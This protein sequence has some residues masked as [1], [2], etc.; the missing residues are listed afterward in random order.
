VK[1]LKKFYS[2]L[3]VVFVACCLNATPSF[4]I[5]SAL[6]LKSIFSESVDLRLEVPVE[7]Q[8]LYSELLVGELHRFGLK[9]LAPQYVLLVDRSPKVQAIFLLWIQDTDHVQFIGA[10]PVST[11][12]KGGFKYFETPLGI[13]SHTIENS[14]FRAEGTENEQGILGYGHKGM[15]VYDFGW[16]SARKT[17]QE[18]NGIMRLQVHSTDPRHLEARLGSVQSMGCVRIPAALNTLIDHYGLL[19]ADYEQ[20]M[21]DGKHFWVLEKNREPTPWSGR[22]LIIVDSNRTTRPIWSPSRQRAKR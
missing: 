11:G 16:V 20:S 6:E 1:H 15:R 7:E 2:M 4:A 9:E 14:D 19:D 5:E 17:W 10:S 22:Y 12:R 8:E 3:T 18:G 21:A 13:F